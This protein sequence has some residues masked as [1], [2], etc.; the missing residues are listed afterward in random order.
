V[1][2][3]PSV[4][5]RY[6]MHSL[7]ASDISGQTMPKPSR[8]DIPQTADTIARAKADCEAARDEARRTTGLE[9]GPDG[10]ARLPLGSCLD[11][12]EHLIDVHG[13]RAFLA[14]AAKAAAM[15]H[16]VMHF[17]ETDRVASLLEGGK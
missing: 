2:T 7:L 11:D 12:I 5:E 6:S 10:F 15:R 13:L 3:G 9:I 14:A 16:I 17:R 8:P 1:N 4:K